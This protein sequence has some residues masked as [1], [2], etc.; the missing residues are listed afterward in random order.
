L[1]PSTTSAMIITMISWMGETS[2]MERLLWR[3]W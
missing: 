1:G 2:G 3:R